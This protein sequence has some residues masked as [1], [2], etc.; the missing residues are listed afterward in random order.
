MSAEM[1]QMAQRHSRGESER[2]RN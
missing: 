2:F 1:V